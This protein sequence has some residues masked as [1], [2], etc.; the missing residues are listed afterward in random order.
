MIGAGGGS[1]AGVDDDE[2]IEGE[3]DAG[4]VWK[5]TGEGGV[6]ER[7]EGCSEAIGPSPP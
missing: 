4:A 1:G 6:W 3:E 7:T 2:L 5:I